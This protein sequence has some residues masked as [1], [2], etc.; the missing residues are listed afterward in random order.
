MLVLLGSV[1]LTVSLILPI[2]NEAA[3]IQNGLEAVLGQDY[4]S[5]K[6]EV[7]VVDGMS[8]DATRE[9]VCEVMASN[10][11]RRIQLLDNPARVVPPALNI[12]V[13]AATGAIVAR[14]DGHA[15]MAPDYIR[16]CVDAMERTGADGVGGVIETVGGSYVARGIARA[17][18]SLFGVGGAGFRTGR[19]EGA[20]VDTVAF[21][22]YRREVF[23]RIG[24]FDE[25]MHLNE[26]DEFNFRLTQSGGRIWLDP[27]I[28]SEYYSR[29]SLRKLWRQYYWYGLYR[30]LLMQK[31]GGVPSWRH[32]VPGGFVLGLV[33][34]AA[35]AL[36]TGQPLWLLAVAGPYALA[37]LAASLW[38]ARGAWR[39]LPLL[40][41][42]FS[43][44]HLAY[45]LGFLVGLWCWRK[46]WGRREMVPPPTS[47]STR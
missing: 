43:I 22:A 4:P 12:A 18:S 40:P 41:V 39:T 37:N 14:M 9:I 19:A 32:L 15:K 36:A 44:L 11:D 24:G 8:D 47:V 20:F 46:G 10:P 23:D 38:T 16:Q 26:D 28:R 17:Q 45:G 34:S 25:E 31:G 42:A 13:R 21:P 5:D 1:L 27:A 29:A 7:I 3:Y 33:L 30:P 2:R 6:V 35:V